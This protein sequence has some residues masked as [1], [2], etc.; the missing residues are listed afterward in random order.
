MHPR[1]N[2]TLVYFLFLTSSLLL[3]GTRTSASSIENASIHAV[4]HQQQEEE[5]HQISMESEEVMLP[6]MLTT[7]EDQIPK[8]SIDAINDTDSAICQYAAGHHEKQDAAGCGV[9]SANNRLLI[10]N[11]TN[12][13]V[14]LPNMDTDQIE[15]DDNPE[16]SHIKYDKNPA[17]VVTVLDDN[18]YSR[19]AQVPNDSSLLQERL[20]VCISNSHQQDSKIS[21][22][23]K[24]LQELQQKLIRSESNQ[25]YLKNNNTLLIKLSKECTKQKNQL[26]QENHDIMTQLKTLE[27]KYITKISLLKNNIKEL[28]KKLLDAETQNEQKSSSYFDS[29]EEANRLE[30]ELQLMYIKS[31]STYVNTTLIIQDIGWVLM[32]NL[33][34]VVNIC[35]NILYSSIVTDFQRKVGNFLV[36]PYKKRFLAVYNKLHGKEHLIAMEKWLKSIDAIEGLR[37]TLVSVVVNLSKAGLN[38]LETT[39][40]STAQIQDNYDH[41]FS[42]HI[43]SRHMARQRHYD[44]VFRMHGL[45][46]KDRRGREHNIRHHYPI[47]NNNKFSKTGPKVYQLVKTWLRYAER[48]AENVVNRVLISIFLLLVYRVIRKIVIWLLRKTSRNGKF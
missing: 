14:F 20:D 29:V 48:N 47:S 35:E 7:K 31:Q 6:T 32:N 10:K 27:D 34:R 24:E 36:K 22:N 23:L 3:F 37:L 25:T 16:I 5:H 17:N 46:K 43:N 12:S 19:T 30:K 41:D 21:S 45:N 42:H 2:I 40:F 15:H 13:T 4:S 28:H 11:I 1:K 44:Y 8:V 33:D 26:Q 18:D 38:Y 39:K 9:T